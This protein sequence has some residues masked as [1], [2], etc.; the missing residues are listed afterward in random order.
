MMF[1]ENSFMAQDR[2][3]DM[4]WNPTSSTSDFLNNYFGGGHYIYIMGHNGD[5][6]NDSPAYDECAWI[7]Q[8]LSSNNFVPSDIDKR[9]VYKDVM[10]INMPLTV[11]NKQFL[12]TDVKYR[13]R[14][15][16]PY[17]KGFN[18]ATWEA[19]SPV[20]GNLPMYTFSTGDL[21]TVNDDLVAA[22]D[23]L[24]L[25]NVVPNPYYAY[26]GY[27]AN[28]LQTTVKITNL[29]Q[30]CVVSIYT[31]NG[32]LIRQFR[33]D[34]PR[35]SVDWDLKNTAGIPIAGGVYLIHVKV[36]GVGEK[37]IKF[38]GALRP[39]DLDSF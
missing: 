4:M 27:E 32:M 13:I 19:G 28:Q 16:R 14:V 9:N 36:D 3:T 10:W 25:I 11:P 29:P 31:V 37:V 30:K 15:T 26:S 12:G 6:D 33:K 7:Y 1:G 23:A 35:T 38:F 34:E 21:F 20:N 18:N 24:D 39:V 2:G 5:T 22:E 8:R 17:R